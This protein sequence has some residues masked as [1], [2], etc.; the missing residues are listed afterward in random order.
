MLQTRQSFAEITI[1][2]LNEMY[3]RFAYGMFEDDRQK[4]MPT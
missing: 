3:G 1:I 2:R 4:H